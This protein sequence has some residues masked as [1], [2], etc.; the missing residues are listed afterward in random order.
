MRAT[1][2]HNGLLDAPESREEVDQVIHRMRLEAALRDAAGWWGD[3]DP[4]SIKERGVPPTSVELPP[5][6]LT[7]LAELLPQIR[8]NVEAVLGDCV[9][10]ESMHD[11]A[12]SVRE[13]LRLL[14][15][16]RERLDRVA[17]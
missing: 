15:G 4:W 6:A 9:R 12:P 16:I 2:P 1:G 10:H 13:E 3:G 14:D 11:E 7:P 5:S 17:A 8:T